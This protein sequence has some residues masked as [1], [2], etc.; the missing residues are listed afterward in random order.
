MFTWDSRKIDQE[1][2]AIEEAAN[3]LQR[4]SIRSCAGLCGKHAVAGDRYCE[5]CRD[6]IAALAEMRAE[7]LRRRALRKM[8]SERF[9]RYVMSE[10]AG[11]HFLAYAVLPMLL[12]CLVSQ[13]G[14][15]KGWW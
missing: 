13:V 5:R 12:L 11:W 15:W 9:W 6:E 10:R 14:K 2:D 7:F 4:A 1:L 8:R 3:R